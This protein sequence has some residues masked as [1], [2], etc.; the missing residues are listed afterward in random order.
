MRVFVLFGLG[1]CG[2]ARN[3]DANSL[4]QSVV[5]A[6]EGEEHNETAEQWPWM[7]QPQQKTSHSYFNVT[8]YGSRLN[9]FSIKAGR[10]C[11][12]WISPQGNV[13]VNCKVKEGTENSGFLEVIS[14]KFTLGA[15]DTYFMEEGGSIT[16][17]P[18]ALSVVAP[19]LRDHNF[20]IECPVCG[21]DCN[22]DLNRMSPY[23]ATN[24]RN[25]VSLAPADLKT[26]FKFSIN[27]AGF[28][29]V[30]LFP[31]PLELDSIWEAKDGKD[32][33]D[34]MPLSKLPPFMLN[35]LQDFHLREDFNSGWRDATG[36]TIFGIH[37]K[38]TI[39]ME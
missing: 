33:I 22:V 32:H 21:H 20:K 18:L 29:R 38:S 13:H 17:V 19:K 16:G 31:C 3:D 37:V 35:Q 9:E 15:S 4:I 26:Q 12:K 27:Q 23:F 6:H 10:A 7:W 30:H 39:W 5:Q 36:K 24:L 14:P 34:S 28:M 25:A 11:H 8:Y 1:L 2:F